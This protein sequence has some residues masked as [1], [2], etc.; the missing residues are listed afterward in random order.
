MRRISL[1]ILCLAWLASL[2][3]KHGALLA[4]ADSLRASGDTYAAI[5]EYKRY[6]SYEGEDRVSGEVFLRLALASGELGEYRDALAYVEKAFFAAAT[7][8]LRAEYAIDKAILL[9]NARNFSLAEFILF[10]EANT[11]RFP[12][13]RAR[14]IHLLALNY[15]LQ[16]KWT[17]AESAIGRI[18]ALSHLEDD[19]HLNALLALLRENSLAEP[20]DPALAKRLSSWLPGLG[21]FYS[22]DIRNG[23]NSFALNAAAIW[24]LADTALRSQYF[25]LVPI[26]LIGWKYYQ[27]G[28]ARAALIATQ[29]NEERTRAGITAAAN[30]YGALLQKL[31][32]V[33]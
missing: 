18:A 32:P 24:W 16:A 13:V 11:G 23:L 28:R 26:A 17:E 29:T 15:I 8:S 14:A 5:T 27:G 12:G 6:V 25:G 21:Q 31:N 19:P 30:L 22:G 9:M 10:R 1:L 20:L 33:W 3:A 7:D 2:P 4:V